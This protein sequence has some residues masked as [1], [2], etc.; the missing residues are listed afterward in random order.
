[1]LLSIQSSNELECGPRGICKYIYNKYKIKSTSLYQFCWE[2]GG[3]LAEFFSS[4]EE[5]KL[6]DILAVDLSYWIGLSD[7]A[8][9][10]TVSNYNIMV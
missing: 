7:A 3:W 8:S 2:N 10:G 6:D 1:M 9:E 5:T 4:A